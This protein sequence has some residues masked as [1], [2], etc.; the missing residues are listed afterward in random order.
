MTRDTI[1]DLVLGC[2]ICMQVIFCVVCRFTRWQMICISDTR[3]GGY[4]E[5]YSNKLALAVLNGFSR[6]AQST[7]LVFQKLVDVHK[8]LIY[9]FLIK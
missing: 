4:D 5:T 7:F 3:V 6:A 8:C 2:S 1:W 9:V